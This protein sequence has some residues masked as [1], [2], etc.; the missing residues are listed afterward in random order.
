MSDTCWCVLGHININME[1]QLRFGLV[2]SDYSLPF[3]RSRHTTFLFYALD[4]KSQFL[5]KH[6]AFHIIQYHQMGQPY[7][8]H[9]I[10]AYPCSPCAA[11]WDH[12]LEK[13]AIPHP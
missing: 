13:Q 8:P 5:S 6:A 10:S 1:P 7:F 9:A 11:R 3:P 12:L 2:T 4:I